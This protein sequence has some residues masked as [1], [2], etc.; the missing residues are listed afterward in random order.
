MAVHDHSLA[1]TVRTQNG[2]KNGFSNTS[3]A[4]GVN[5]VQVCQSK[6]L[7]IILLFPLLSPAAVE[8][9]NERK[10][11]REREKEKKVHF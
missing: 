4:F 10:S 6:E 3:H 9:E 7:Y 5:E 1:D 8:K 11:K 2:G